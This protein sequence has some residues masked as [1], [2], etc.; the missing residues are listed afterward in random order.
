MLRS[1][2]RSETT[3]SHALQREQSSQASRIDGQ[4]PKRCGKDVALML[5][6]DDDHPSVQRRGGRRTISTHCSLPATQARCS[7][8][9]VAPMA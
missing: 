1:I 4:K 5:G 8:A 9:R 7:V 6:S 3:L 2:W